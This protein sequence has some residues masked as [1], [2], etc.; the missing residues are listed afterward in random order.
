MASDFRHWCDLKT[1]K[2]ISLE[3]NG[4]SSQTAT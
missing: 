1:G 4:N 3:I 2:S